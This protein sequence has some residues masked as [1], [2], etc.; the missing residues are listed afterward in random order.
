MNQLPRSAK[1]NAVSFYDKKFNEV[2]FRIYNKTLIY[3]EQLQAFTSFYTHNPNWFFPFSDK[4]V[5][6]K[7]NNMYYLHNIHEIDDSNQPREE[8][9]SK[10]EFVVNKD[11]SNTKVFDNVVF[12]A[13]LENI[14]AFD[15]PMIKDI[16]FKTKTQET[17]ALTINDIDLREDNYRFAIPREKVSNE[18]L[19]KLAS[20]SYLGRM[21]GKYL[22]CDYTFDC[23]NNR[24]FKLPYIKTTYRYSML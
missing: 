15:A 9:I 1:T 22:I 20:Q 5:T 17:S 10:V 8:R 3:N 7:N 11:I 12:S 4:L 16:I 14:D 13:E 24:E 19:N 6:I 23:N 2:W 18:G 21:R